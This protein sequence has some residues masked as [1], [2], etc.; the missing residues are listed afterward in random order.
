MTRQEQIN[1]P[2]PHN[3][4]C[5]LHRMEDW[6]NN[7][8]I[9][10]KPTLEVRYM[11]IPAMIRSKPI[12]INIAN[13][14]SITADRNEIHFHTS[15]GVYR[16]PLSLQDYATCF[17][18][19]GFEYLNKSALVQMSNIK[20]YDPVNFVVTFDNEFPS[21]GCFVSRRNRYKVLNLKK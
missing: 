20:R 3:H 21:Q 16:P 4:H 17:E 9:Y 1:K 6:L 15:C 13:L 18:N 2:M 11:Y 12:M 5:I 7:S 14:N 10:V 19:Y 8:R